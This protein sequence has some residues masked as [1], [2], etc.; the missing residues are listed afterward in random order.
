MTTKGRSRGIPHI[1]D[2]PLKEFH[3]ALNRISEYE[4]TEK[5][6][7]SEIL[8]GIDEKGFYTSR[9]SHGG[10]RVYDVNEYGVTFSNTYKRSAH[11]ALE[12]VLT[13]LKSAGLKPGDQVEA[14][15][16]FGEVPNVV[17]YSADTNYIIFLRTTEGDVDIDHLTQEL[18]GQSLSISITT[19]FTDNGIY[20]DYRL[21]T[22]SWKFS[23]TPVIPNTI[24]IY[25]SKFS[26]QLKVKEEILTTFVRKTSSAFGPKNGWIEG[27]V[28][29]NP[30]TNHRFKVVDKD[31]FLSQKK[32]QWR[33]RDE[34]MEYPRSPKYV[35]SV[36]GN[37]L[38]AFSSILDAEELGTIMA[39]K[40]LRQIG[41]TTTERLAFLA[42][43]QS[44]TTLITHWNSTIKFY[45]TVLLRRV[46]KYEEK[47][48]VLD[49]GLSPT[50]IKRT[51]ETFAT[52]Y[53]Q[54]GALEE[55]ILNA[56]STEALIFVFL[57]K[58]LR[59]LE[60]ET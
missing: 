13:Q 40:Y 24:P 27:I 16:L 20:I 52:L 46:D 48:K 25:V 54:I 14:E 22:N 41:N 5:V 56:K 51:K 3:K 4:I 8:F 55:G 2:L 58:Q 53:A 44:F 37:M 36:Y 6:D 32:H 11:I 12:S 18:D 7:G 17:T 29:S 49:H 15:V 31:V 59:D 45:K 50:S 39:K 43:G 60:N 9:E 34:L 10:G 38:A 35:T 23:R 47:I 30:I 42:A 19:P 28:L 26:N 1:E 33:H 21:E 57:E